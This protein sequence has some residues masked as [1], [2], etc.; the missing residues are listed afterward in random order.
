MKKILI[1][2][3][4]KTVLLKLKIEVE[5]FNFIEADYAET[6]S[7]AK[8]L[9]DGDVVYH[10][11]I[12]DLNLPDA[13]NGEIV[14]LAIEHNIPSVIL[15]ATN[16]KDLKNKIFNKGIIDFIHKNDPSSIE[17]AMESTLRALKNYDTTI[18]VVDDSPLSVSTI[19]MMLEKL[20][21]TIL[22]ASDGQEALNVIRKH[23]EIK[24]V[25]TDCEM[26]NIDGLTLTFKL[27][28]IFKKD[29][30]SI[31]GISSNDDQETISKFLRFGANDFVN[32]PFSADELINRIIANLELLD[33]FSKIRDM[34]NTDFLT[35]LYN[36]RYFFESG[37]QIFQKN[38]RKNSNVAIAMLDIDHFKKINDEYGHDVGD[39]A[40][41]EVRNVLEKCLRGSDLIARFGGEEFCV[42]LEEISQDHALELFEKIR[43]EFM[44]N[45]IKISS[46]EINY[47]VSIGVC[48][49]MSQKIDEM[50]SCAD[51]ALYQSKENGRNKV[52][53]KN[54][55]L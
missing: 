50:L 52:T 36:R 48:Y 18:L 29:Q 38:K 10:S 21:I 44:R 28:E 39:I 8:K 26:P 46:G 49:G 32:K 23:P 20:K 16:D 14:D 25:I 11:A 12:L 35:G 13:A 17:F 4:T 54:S 40:I 33:L 37:K 43:K 1:V 42:F 55:S 27:R 22:T 30:L 47:T 31:I 45:S 3:D 24:L 15:S 51:Q 5:K 7:D 19:K 6:Y 34:A 53:L 41:K 9:L 2:D